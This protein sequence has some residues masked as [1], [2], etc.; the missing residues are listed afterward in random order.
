[1]Q[2]LKK[3]L[4]DSEETVSGVMGQKESLARQLKEVQDEGQAL[5]QQVATLKEAVGAMIKERDASFARL[6]EEKEHCLEMESLLSTA[7]QQLMQLKEESL[8]LQ[9][10]RDQLEKCRQELVASKEQA[11]DELERLRGEMTEREHRSKEQI[12]DL[13]R[14]LTEANDLAVQLQNQKTEVV[15]Q[16]EELRAELRSLTESEGDRRAA[17]E[18]VIELEKEVALLKG[19]Q[20]GGTEGLTVPAELAKELEERI[21]RYKENIRHLEDSLTASGNQLKEERAQR[22][23]LE[24]EQEGREAERNAAMKQLEEKLETATKECGDLEEVVVRAKAMETECRSALEHCQSELASEKEAVVQWKTTAESLDQRIQELES[25]KNENVEMTARVQELQELQKESLRQKEAASEEEMTLR[26]MLHHS[27]ESLKNLRENQSAERDAQVTQMKE[28]QTELKKTQK[29]CYVA[30]DRLKEME[31]E[32]GQLKAVLMKNASRLEEETQTHRIAKQRLSDEQET[33]QHLRQQLQEALS[34]IQSSEVETWKQQEASAAQQKEKED[35]NQKRQQ[36]LEREISN[37]KSAI[38][39][40]EQQI[41]AH[42][43]DLEKIRE[44]AEGEKEKL[45]RAIVELKKRLDRAAAQ[46]KKME[47]E[48]TEMQDGHF[49]EKERLSAEVSHHQHQ[50]EKFGTELKD[51]KA[52]AHL[53]VKNKDQELNALRAELQHRADVEVDLR[54]LREQFDDLTVERD[55]IREELTEANE[56]FQV[57]LDDLVAGFQTEID[58]KTSA[59]LQTR[60]AKDAVATAAQ[61]WK[62]KAEHFEQELL[63][64]AQEIAVL[65]AP[66]PYDLSF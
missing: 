49:A 48:G 23:T 52:K 51:Y 55:N 31:T 10:E 40:R 57:H 4:T 16:Q 15:K 2:Q 22:D 28:L 38:A 27:E 39:A 62:N 36:E 18:R 25:L 44:A 7:Q 66:K 6:S 64:K 1:M 41:G 54:V 12:E 13:Y 35:A 29:E 32:I 14:Q 34:K 50:A 3:Q 33:T 21:E 56:R 61:E 47:L 37:L 46:I 59:L 8:S 58:E 53:L 45:K 60:S 63:Q 9:T 19:C 24:R 43:E 26:E 65:S 30:E 11:D 5:Q 20:E 42:E 17:C